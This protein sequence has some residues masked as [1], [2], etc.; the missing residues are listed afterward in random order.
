MVYFNPNVYSASVIDGI[1]TFTGVELMLVLLF[2]AASGEVISYLSL[3]LALKS[4]S[5]LPAVLLKSY[6]NDGVTGIV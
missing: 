5:Y 6:L 3:A 4:S 2:F 1:S